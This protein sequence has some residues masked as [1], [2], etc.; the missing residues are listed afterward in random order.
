[1][2]ADDFVF[3]DELEQEALTG[4]AGRGQR[5]TAGP[6]P[7]DDWAVRNGIERRSSMD[8]RAHADRRAGDRRGTG[9]S[10]DPMNIYL[11]EMGDQHLLSHEEEMELARMVEEGETS[12]QHAVL[13]NGSYLNDLHFPS[14]TCFDFLQNIISFS[15]PLY[16]QYEQL[17]GIFLP[18]K[19]FFI[20][21]TSE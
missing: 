4:I 12:I 13:R 19:L 16:S 10:F 18:N 8:R 5:D 15:I 9:S 1:M 3:D 11:R 7:E 20:I 14:L 6:L 17:T 2:E 21:N